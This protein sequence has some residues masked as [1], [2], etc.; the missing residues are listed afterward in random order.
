MRPAKAGTLF[1]SKHHIS[2]P[3]VHHSEVLANP[4]LK[5]KKRHPDSPVRAKEVLKGPQAIWGSRGEWGGG[6]EKGMK[7]QRFSNME[8]LYKH[9]EEETYRLVVGKPLVSGSNWQWRNLHLPWWMPFVPKSFSALRIKKHSQV[10][11][12]GNSLTFHS[13]PP[14]CI[15]I[16]HTGTHAPWKRDLVHSVSKA[17]QRPNTPVPNPSPF[18]QP[19]STQRSSPK[20]AAGRDFG[21][22]LHYPFSA[23]TMFFVLPERK[24]KDMNPP[25]FAISN[26]DPGQYSERPCEVRYI[27]RGDMWQAGTVLPD[28]ILGDPQLQHSPPLFPSQ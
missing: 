23:W 12:R 13:P 8:G 10:Q 7:R 18:S 1:V 27:V 17:P 19:S 4:D 20:A 21:G 24:I 3:H 2:L 15:T 14:H 11:V 5:K 6:K 9:R 22:S 25:P 16:H 26:P 28:T